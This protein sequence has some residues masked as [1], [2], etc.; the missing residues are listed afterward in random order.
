MGALCVQTVT[1]DGIYLF[2]SLSILRR[3][4]VNTTDNA[5]S[6]TSVSRRLVFFKGFVE[7]SSDVFEVTKNLL[8]DLI[9]RTVTGCNNYYLS[10][11][12]QLESN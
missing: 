3:I 6:V 5:K 9:V 8:L 11:A 1:G 2:L 4:K 10:D 12:K 7:A